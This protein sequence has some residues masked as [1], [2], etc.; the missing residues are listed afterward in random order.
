MINLETLSTNP[1]ATIIE[2]G[3]VLFDPKTDALGKTFEVGINQNTVNRH[4][5]LKTV[6]WWFKQSPEALKNVATTRGGGLSLVGAMQ[7]FINFARQNGVSH[8][9]SHGASFDIPILRSVAE[10]LNLELPWKFWNEMDTRTLYFVKG[11]PLVVR[12]GIHP[13]ALDDAIYQAKCVQ[14]AYQR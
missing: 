13:S 2:I 8:A 12:K 6:A 5:D 1:A 9:W 7:Q 11:P 14:E 3:A 4:V 10:A